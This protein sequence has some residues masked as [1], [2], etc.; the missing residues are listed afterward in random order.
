MISHA[1]KESQDAAATA[2]ESDEG[3]LHLDLFDY[4]KK[5]LS[6]LFSVHTGIK[7]FDPFLL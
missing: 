6:L 3:K 4:I 1:S 7:D 2:T 5:S